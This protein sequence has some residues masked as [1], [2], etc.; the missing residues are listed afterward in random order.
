M[1]IPNFI[2]KYMAR[3]FSVESQKNRTADLDDFN[4]GFWHCN[5][6]RVSETDDF[7]HIPIDDLKKPMEVLDS[8]GGT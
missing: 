1:G 3:R 5:Q 8:R 4:P 6:E 7:P 2:R